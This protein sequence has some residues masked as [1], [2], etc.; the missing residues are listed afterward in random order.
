MKRPITRK[1]A[2]ITIIAILFLALGARGQV[3]IDTAK[4]IKI[5]RVSD[6][7][8]RADM[9]AVEQYR[10]NPTAVTRPTEAYQRLDPKTGGALRK[11]WF[12]GRY[13]ENL[14]WE[15]LQGFLREKALFFGCSNIIS[16]EHHPNLLMFDFYL[17]E[18]KQEQEVNLNRYL[19][20]GMKKFPAK[21]RKGIL[22]VVRP[23]LLPY[24]VR[25]FE[26]GGIAMEGL[27]GRTSAFVLDGSTQ[28]E[29]STCSFFFFRYLIQKGYRK[30]NSFFHDYERLPKKDGSLYWLA[31][32]LGLKKEWERIRKMV[33]KGKLG[34]YTANELGHV[35]ASKTH[36]NSSEPSPERSQAGEAFSDG[37]S[38]TWLLKN[39]NIPVF[40]LVLNS[41]INRVQQS[42]APDYAETERITNLV[43]KKMEISIPA[44]LREKKRYGDARLIE[45]LFADSPPKTALLKIYILFSSRDYKRLVMKPFVRGFTEELRR[46]DILGIFE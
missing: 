22:Y 26:L 39:K 24:Q 42:G 8:N 13:G 34:T 36:Q 21:N 31:D 11:K 45:S 29:N 7:L 20:P 44:Q 17:F 14:S 6:S 43:I 46:G 12:L 41:Y 15:Q 4:I 28:A 30:T 38:L 40:V 23:I 16:L 1:K 2:A 25:K 3:A 18:I 27:L 33:A 35:I 32:S 19:L 37:T 9:V 10:L 5:I